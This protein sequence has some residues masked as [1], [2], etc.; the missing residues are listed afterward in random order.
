MENSEE[1]FTRNSLSPFFYNRILCECV[2]LFTFK[3][4]CSKID[5]KG[6]RE[7]FLT[8][9]PTEKVLREFIIKE[10][11][12]SLS[13]NELRRMVELCK[14]HIGGETPRDANIRTEL[15]LKKQNN[16]CAACG[17][18]AKGG[19]VFHEDHIVPYS[20]VYENLNKE[21][22]RQALCEGCNTSKQASPFFALNL[23]VEKCGKM[24][25]TLR[26]FF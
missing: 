1:F 21:K 12:I 15:W 9:R 2:L 23:F 7:V 10:S 20:L 16:L 17:C 6:G 18:L 11:S 3:Q 14:A 22:N 8:R 19:V 24:N 5:S 4:L 13:E 26:I 25:P